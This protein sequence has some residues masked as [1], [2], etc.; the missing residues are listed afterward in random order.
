ME[1]ICFVGLAVI[2]GIGAVAIKA[3]SNSHRLN[4]L[5]KKV[6]GSGTASSRMEQAI[7]DIVNKTN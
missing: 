3:F 7:D 5:N 2:A 4:K 1:T 6:A